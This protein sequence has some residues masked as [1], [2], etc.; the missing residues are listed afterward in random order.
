M[1]CKEKVKLMGGSWHLKILTSNSSFFSESKILLVF[2]LD[3][4]PA[5]K[6]TLRGLDL[7]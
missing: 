3:D 7:V 4:S 6:T 5:T 1:Y 2:F